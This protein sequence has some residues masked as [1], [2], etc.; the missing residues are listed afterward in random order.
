MPF[1]QQMAQARDTDDDA[2]SPMVVHLDAPVADGPKCT[3]R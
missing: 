2:R 1:D 3:A